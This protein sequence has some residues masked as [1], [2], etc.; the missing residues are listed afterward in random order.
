MTKRLQVKHDTKERR[1]EL[2]INPVWCDIGSHYVSE[3]FMRWGAWDASVCE[4]CYDHFT[5]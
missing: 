2:I 5:E 1:I 3:D 4:D